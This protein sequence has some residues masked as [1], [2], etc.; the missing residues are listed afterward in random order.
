MRRIM[1]FYEYSQDLTDDE[2]L[3][4]ANVDYETTGISD[5]VLWIG[6]NPK[7]HGY[8]IKVS[9]KLNNFDGTNNFTIT[10]PDYKIIGDVNNKLV[11]STKMEEII[12]FIE[13]NKDIIISYSDHEIITK[14]LLDG[15]VSI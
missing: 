2:L 1:E 7:S 15:I 14:K 9:N 12:D 11:S 10:I 13:K 6:P 3:E 4:M 5:I 8:R